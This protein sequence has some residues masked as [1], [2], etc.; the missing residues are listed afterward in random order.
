MLK[1]PRKPA[2]RPEKEKRSKGYD[3]ENIIVGGRAMSRQFP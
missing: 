3:L 1:L 2:S